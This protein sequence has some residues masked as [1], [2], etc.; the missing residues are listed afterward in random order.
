M[1]TALRPSPSM[2]QVRKLSLRAALP[3]D[4]RWA[5]IAIGDALHTASI[6]DSNHG[7]WLVIRSLDLGKI[8]SRSSSATISL[9]IE[10]AVQ[11][12]VRHAIPYHNP[13]AERAEAVLF[14]S[15]SEGIVQLG[16]RLAQGLPVQAWYWNKLLPGWA[17]AHSQP[18]RW[19]AILA[20]LRSEADAFKTTGAL[21]A[22]ALKSIP[23]SLFVS[24]LDSPLVQQWVFQM[25]SPAPNPLQTPSHIETSLAPETQAALSALIEQ[26]RPDDPRSGHSTGWYDVLRV[27]HR[28][29]TGCRPL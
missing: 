23:S 15:R 14:P 3:Q 12:A 28:F 8:S 4:A 1:P 21:V 10:K 18:K 22:S 25:G 19:Q 11:R 2:R 16:K 20:A 7:R 9:Q 29:V 17:H 27:W 26:Y 5:A 6:P 13:A 24:Y